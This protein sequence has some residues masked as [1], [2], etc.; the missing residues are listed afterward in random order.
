MP[1]IGAVIKE[2]VRRI[3]RK[4]I[5]AAWNPLRKKLSETRLLA[6]ELK[7]K[8]AALEAASDRLVRESSARA[9]EK[10]RGSG[11]EAKDARIGPRSIRSQRKRI[12]LTR[13][14]FGRLVG[15]SANTVY[16]WETG[17]VAPR[18]GSRTALIGVRKI[19]AKEAK[20]LLAHAP[21]SS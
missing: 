9:L 2:E 11:A 14:E 6:F 5:R 13:A 17:Q 12:H 4:E 16:L 10:T 1:N 15:V 3:A 21:S 20:R 18:S 19:R 7:R 8:V